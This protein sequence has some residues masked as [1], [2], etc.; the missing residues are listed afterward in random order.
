MRGCT[1]INCRNIQFRLKF[2]HAWRG[3]TCRP[4]ST[5]TKGRPSKG[6]PCRSNRSRRTVEG[7]VGPVAGVSAAWMPRPSPQGWVYGVPRNRTHPAIPRNARCC[8][9]CC[10]CPGIGRCRAQPCRLTHPPY[11]CRRDRLPDPRSAG[12][13]AASRLQRR[14]GFNR[15]A[16]LAVAIGAG[17]RH[18]LARRACTPW[19][20]TRCRRL[21]KALPAAMCC[22]GH[23]TGR[24]PRAG[25]A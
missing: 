20:A 8:F 14:P 25:H 2:I 6:R 24:A 13:T 16:A 23:R 7:G 19:P 15:A 22:A 3:S 1:S 4:R 5:P 9:G 10:H 18:A 17:R 11:T 21:G 12:C